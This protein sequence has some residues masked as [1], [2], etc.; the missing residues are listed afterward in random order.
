MDHQTLARS[1]RLAYQLF[2][3]SAAQGQD[4]ATLAL[5]VLDGKRLCLGLVMEIQSGKLR[6]VSDLAALHLDR[7]LTISAESFERLWRAFAKNLH[8]PA[9]ALLCDRAT[10]E[11]LVTTDDKLGYLAAVGH[12]QPYFY[13][14]ELD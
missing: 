12:A 6:N 3:A 5:G 11:G 2:R 14:V 13:R 10:F 1:S 9:A 4:S 8:A 7:P